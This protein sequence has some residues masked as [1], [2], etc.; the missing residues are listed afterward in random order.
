MLRLAGIGLAT[1]LAYL[2]LAWEYYYQ[3]YRFN[4]DDE[5]ALLPKNINQ[6]FIGDALE[7][8]NK[9]W[10]SHLS[11]HMLLPLQNLIVVIVMTYFPKYLAFICNKCGKVCTVLFPAYR[12]IN[13]HEILLLHLQQFM[14]ISTECLNT[15]NKIY[16]ITVLKYSKPLHKYITV[17]T[18]WRILVLVLVAPVMVR[19]KILIEKKFHTKAPLVFAAL[20]TFIALAAPF[21]LFGIHFLTGDVF[22]AIKLKPDF[23][24]SQMIREASPY[25]VYVFRGLKAPTLHYSILKTPFD[26]FLIVSDRSIRLQTRFKS[27]RELALIEYKNTYYALDALMV[28]GNNFIFAILFMIFDRFCV[29]SFCSKFIQHTTAHLILEEFAHIGLFKYSS[30]GYTFYNRAVTQ[31][32]NQIIASEGNCLEI[33]QSLVNIHLDFYNRQDLAYSRLYEFINGKEGIF[34]RIT[35]ILEMNKK[36]G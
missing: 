32:I 33:C 2:D 31:K 36:T 29:E 35:A 8:Y 13:S 6:A 15:F 20:N 19:Y 22:P 21:V 24:W 27:I 11:H 12:G 5:I 18:L 3:K 14:I 23:E 17:A 10:V 9:H 16:Y 30:F 7:D 28:L 34:R 1:A 4:V 26:P 25:E